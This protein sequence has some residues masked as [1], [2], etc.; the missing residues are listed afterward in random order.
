MNIDYALR[1]ASTDNKRIRPCLLKQPFEVI[2]PVKKE[3]KY[4]R[5][6]AQNNC[7]RRQGI[8]NKIEI[9]KQR[10]KAEQYSRATVAPIVILIWP[11]ALFSVPDE[12]DAVDDENEAHYCGKTRM[13]IS[14]FLPL[15]ILCT[16]FCCRFA[17]CREG[18][19]NLGKTA[20]RTVP[21]EPPKLCLAIFMQVLVISFIC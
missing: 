13:F 4:W 1:F 8:L 2:L 21:V 10:R 9:I 5:K 15:W 11:D 20:L 7:T 14:F 12:G 16:F 17:I 19:R 3:R 18:E 6:K